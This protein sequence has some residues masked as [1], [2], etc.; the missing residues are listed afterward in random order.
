[1]LTVFEARFDK[2]GVKGDPY[3]TIVFLIEYFS[4]FEGIGDGAY[5]TLEDVVSHERGNTRSLIIAVCSLMQRMGWD[6][7]YLYNGREHYLGINFSDS[8]VIRQGHWV[9]SDGSRYY[10]KVFDLR[11][12]VG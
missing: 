3:A 8:W 1:M 10:L 6:V 2:A 9:E 4:A 12:P 11:T 5:Y 7:Q